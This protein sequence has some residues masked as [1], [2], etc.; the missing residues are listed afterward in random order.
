MRLHKVRGASELG[1]EYSTV[2]V[3]DLLLN[4]ATLVLFVVLVHPLPFWVPP[5]ENCFFLN[6]A[7]EVFFYDFM[8]QI[9]G[10]KSKEN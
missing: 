4:K 10:K 5:P 2:P 8:M 6:T 3:P 7:Q 1:C 9:V